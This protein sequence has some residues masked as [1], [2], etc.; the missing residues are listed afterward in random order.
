[1]LGD[2]ARALSG[3][4]QR[5]PTTEAEYERRVRR[6]LAYA[7]QQGLGT[8]WRGLLLAY[9]VL[10]RDLAP[11]S[12]RKYRAALRF[13][14]ERAMGLEAERLFSER[15][16]V[17]DRIWRA[18]R[19]QAALAAGKSRKR[20][21][22]LLRE[23]PNELR[24]L[25]SA[26]LYGRGTVAALTAGDIILATPIVGCRPGEWS[27]SHLEGNMLTVVNAKFR[28]GVRGNGPERT[29]V[30]DRTLITP[31]EMDA[32]RR[33]VMCM[34]GRSWN[35]VRGRI[36]AALKDALKSLVEQGVIPR[37]WLRLRLYDARHQFAAEAKSSLDELQGEVAAVMGHASAQTAAYH[38]GK[39]RKAQ[40]PSAVRPTPDAVARVKP[41]TIARLKELTEK[42]M[43][44]A[45]ARS[46]RAA[47]AP[48][49]DLKR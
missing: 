29:M 21:G 20:R 7:A 14:V 5:S 44:R 40:R 45:K 18:A 9:E 8:D 42:R 41:R 1:M 47:P 27:N 34:A 3:A 17:I 28:E 4:G 15:A 23:M 22:G 48:A 12:R 49:P 13:F 26:H 37:K 33:L 30:L 31:D 39:R 36:S 19:E 43:A 38:Y 10:S 16:A 11:A 46:N 24:S 32:I 6:F 25:L 35:S 2:D